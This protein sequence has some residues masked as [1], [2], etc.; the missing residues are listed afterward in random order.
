MHGIDHPSVLSQVF[1]KPLTVRE[2]TFARDG[3][4]KHVYAHL[5]DWICARVNE[6]RHPVHVEVFKTSCLRPDSTSYSRDDLVD[7]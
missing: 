5:F 1:T 3:L 7:S 4:A 2:A 6:V